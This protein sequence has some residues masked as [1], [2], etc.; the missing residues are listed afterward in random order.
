MKDLAGRVTLI[1]GAASGIGR[2]MAIRFAAAGAV[3]VLWDIRLDLL[4]ETKELIHAET[5]DAE[6]H[7]F[8]CDLSQREEIYRVAVEV[9][10]IVRKV[11]ILVNNAGIVSGKHFLSCEDQLI[12]R[13]MA[14]N[15][16]AHMWLA[17]CFLPAMIEENLGTDLYRWP[18]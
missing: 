7:L 6:V 1:T 10:E 2:L 11:D 9:K 16:M 4:E 13:T 8:R 3:L 12:E 17:K 14:V 5:P 18:S 15:V